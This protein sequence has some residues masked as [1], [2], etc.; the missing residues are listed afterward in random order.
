MWMGIRWEKKRKT[1]SLRQI[2]ISTAQFDVPVEEG[3]DLIVWRWLFG[4]RGRVGPWP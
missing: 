3:A 4:G 2:V 1:G